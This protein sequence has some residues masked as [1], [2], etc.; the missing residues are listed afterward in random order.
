MQPLWKT[1]WRFL[2]KLKIGLPYDPAI[3]LLDI[4]LKKMKTLTWKDICT[5]MFTATLFTLSKTRKH[6]TG[7]WMHKENVVYIYRG[8]LL[9]LQK[10]ILLFV[11]T[12]MELE[13]L[14]AKLNRLNRERQIPYGLTF[15]WNLKNKKK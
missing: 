2:K 14:Y 8:L 13:G 4:Y 1:V 6:P 11:T 5:L 7:L 3:I 12:W 15:M 10:E 9:S